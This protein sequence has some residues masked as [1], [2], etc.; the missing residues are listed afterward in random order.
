MNRSHTEE[1]CSLAIE[2]FLP[3][4]VTGALHVNIPLQSAMK[5]GI[6]ITKILTNYF[7]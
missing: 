7:Y 3:E 6:V 2:I 4:Q 1:D 5:Y